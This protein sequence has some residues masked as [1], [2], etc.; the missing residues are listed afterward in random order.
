ML[1]SDRFMADFIQLHMLVSYPPSNLNRDDLGRPKT[2]TMG[3]TDRLRISSQSLKRAWR[4]SEMFQ[5]E[6]MGE[7]GKRTRGLGKEIFSALMEGDTVYGRLYGTDGDERRRDPV[8]EP[9][10]KAW[11]AEIASAFVDKIGETTEGEPA[12]EEEASQEAPQKGKRKGKE[13]KSNVKEASL[14]TSQV[15]FVSPDEIRQIDRLLDILRAENRGPTKEEREAILSKL[16]SVDIAMFG[17]FLA[18]QRSHTVE[19]A[20]QVAHAITVHEAVVEEDYFTAVDDLNKGDT[21]GAAHLNLS[22]FGA[23]LFYLYVCIN[24]TCL[25]DNLGGD[26]D[27]ADRAITSL[28]TTMTQVAPTGK[29]A[30]YASRAWAPYLLAERGSNQPRSLSVAFLSPRNVFTMERMDQYGGMLGAATTQLE[31]VRVNMNAIYGV[32]DN[33]CSFNVMEKEGSLKAV[34]KFV[35]KKPAASSNG[36]AT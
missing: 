14:E 15:V 20:V 26:T 28:V 4:V 35:T 12:A 6:F 34:L 3:M 1:R 7:L 2:A 5:Q 36:T 21:S 27:L 18:Q 22:E 11:A 19:A 30:S 23:G 8:S 13:K 10:A 29:Q 31:E 25:L 24:R 32:P 17:R 9:L 33:S 16:Y